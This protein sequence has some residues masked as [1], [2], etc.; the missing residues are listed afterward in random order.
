VPPTEKVEFECDVNPLEKLHERYLKD[1][2]V[3]LCVYDDDICLETFLQK[4]TLCKDKISPY[5]QQPHLVR[6]MEVCL[7]SK[8]SCFVRKNEESVVLGRVFLVKL[9][10]VF[11]ITRYKNYKSELLKARDN[12]C[13]D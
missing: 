2:M 7:A 3:W 6:G 4:I 11:D 1:N 5:H 9:D 10:Q 13:G 8:R 12:Q